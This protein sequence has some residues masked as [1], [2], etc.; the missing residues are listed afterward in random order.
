MVA[1][2]APYLPARD[3]RVNS[4]ALITAVA[5]LGIT[6]GPGIKVA[7][8]KGC[9]VFGEKSGWKEFGK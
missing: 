5:N 8:G 4:R 3:Y 6:W 1:M 9:G 2:V 7:S